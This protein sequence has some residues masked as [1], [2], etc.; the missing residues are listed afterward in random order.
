MNQLLVLTVTKANPF[1]SFTT[2]EIEYLTEYIKFMHPLAASLDYLQG[3]VNSFYGQVLPTLFSLRA[4]YTKL[5]ESQ[6]QGLTILVPVLPKLLVVLQSEKRF[7]AEFEFRE[8]VHEAVIASVSHPKFKLGWLVGDDEKSQIARSLLEDEV[9]KVM[10]E[11]ETIPSSTPPPPQPNHNSIANVF[12]ID[13]FCIM[14]AGTGIDTS[15]QG[16]CRGRAASETNAFLNDNRTELQMLD[17]YPTV[18]KVF[19]RTNTVMCSSA[20]LE[21]TFNYAGILNNPKRGSIS[22]DTFSKSVFLK[23]NESFKKS[24]ADRIQNRNV[25]K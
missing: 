4:Y 16:Q 12:G 6:Q 5:L 11:M 25:K 18:K 23:G 2:R 20:P 8:S 22:P 7:A 3:D 14:Q 1:T 19:K 21:R 9:M 15:G 10:Q 17:S 13:D 24:E